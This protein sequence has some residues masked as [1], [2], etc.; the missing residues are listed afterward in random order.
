M[1]AGTRRCESGYTDRSDCV[2]VVAEW[3][4]RRARFSGRVGRAFPNERRPMTLLGAQFDAV[5]SAMP[6]AIT[7]QVAAITGLTIEATDLA[8]PMGALCRITSLGGKQSTAEVLGQIL[9]L[10]GATNPAELNQPP[11][12]TPPQGAPQIMPQITPGGVA[13]SGTNPRIAMTPIAITPRAIVTSTRE[14]A[15][16]LC[17]LYG[18]LN[19]IR[20]TTLSTTR[21][22]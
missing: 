17:I 2:R 22:A 18:W 12:A 6:Y 15:A 21:S 10:R 5:D 9:R 19:L 14:N 4:P 8:L 1:Q 3:A 13:P 16:D 20:P 11:V 7:G